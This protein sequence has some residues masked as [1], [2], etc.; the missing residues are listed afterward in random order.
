[1]YRC[2]KEPRAE[3]RKLRHVTSPLIK[4][5]CIFLLHSVA[6]KSKLIVE[7]SLHP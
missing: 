6:N 5:I 2:L 7:N 3:K 4:T 1:M